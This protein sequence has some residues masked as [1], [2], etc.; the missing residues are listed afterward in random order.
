MLDNCFATFDGGEMS[1]YLFCR[2]RC[3]FYCKNNVGY[4]LFKCFANATI[5]MWKRHIINAWQSSGL[6]FKWLN[7]ISD[8]F[9]RWF[10]FQ[11]NENAIKG[12]ARW[13]FSFNNNSNNNTNRIGKK[14]NKLTNIVR[15]CY[16]Q[17]HT[18][19]RAANVLSHGK[20]EIGTKATKWKATRMRYIQK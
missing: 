14:Y 11:N 6:D 5:W 3:A 8:Y 7:I 4:R 19:T 20:H 13:C 10:F 16:K 15:F 12:N 1:L 18:H 2:W 17:T 9:R